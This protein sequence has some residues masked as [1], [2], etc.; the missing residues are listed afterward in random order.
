MLLAFCVGFIAVTD[1]SLARLAYDC[2]RTVCVADGGD[3]SHATCR[4]DAN[5][6]QRVIKSWRKL[7]GPNEHLVTFSKSLAAEGTGAV[8]AGELT[9]YQ[10]FVDRSV[11]R[12]N[13]EGHE[14]WQHANLNENGSELDTP[15][16]APVMP[17]KNKHWNGFSATNDEKAFLHQTE[18][19]N[20]LPASERC[21]GQ[22]S[23][24]WEVLSLY[25]RNSLSVMAATIPAM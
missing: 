3:T 14:L 6:M 1:A 16:I 20:A 23:A 17:M 5:K 24:C 2:P 4:F 10:D 21:P 12:D 15:T 18:P 22:P 9:T 13:L 8:R 11:V 25:M 7:A 19:P